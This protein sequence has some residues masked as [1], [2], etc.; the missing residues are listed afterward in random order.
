MES[1][2]IFWAFPV[3]FVLC[4]GVGTGACLLAYR[5]ISTYHSPFHKRYFYYLVAFYG[6]GIYGLWGQVAFLGLLNMRNDSGISLGPAESFLAVLGIPFLFLSWGML[7]GMGK[8]LGHIPNGRKSAVLHFVFLGLTLLG[9]WTVYFFSYPNQGVDSPVFQYGLITLLLGLELAYLIVFWRLGTRN[10]EREGK[11]QVRQT[12]ILLMGMGWLLRALTL[13]FVT[14]FGW[15]T[16]VVLLIFF[17]SNGFPVLYLYRRGD[18]L[19]D[20]I[21]SDTPNAEKKMRLY[22]TY[23]L[24]PRERE[25]V[26]QLCLGKT[27][28]QIADTLFISLQTVKDH[29]HRIYSKI[30][31]HSR[32]KLVQMITG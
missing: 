31:V 7:A 29:T 1:S 30:G 22:E 32:L 21:G 15:R 17:L 28:R 11:R 14:E 19:F 12:F 8:A 25:I 3:C 13:P 6:F 24:T 4:L 2:L 10:K 5:G 9:M 20:P 27:N 18:D 26:E 23:G 16:P